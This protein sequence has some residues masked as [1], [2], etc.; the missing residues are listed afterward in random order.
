[1]RRESSSFFAPFPKTPISGGKNVLRPQ[2]VD[3]L[4]NQAKSVQRVPE[5]A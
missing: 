4:V 3:R 1:M 2:H 5:L